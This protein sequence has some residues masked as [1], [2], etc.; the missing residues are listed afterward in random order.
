MLFPA[1]RLPGAGQW[2]NWQ[3]LVLLD[4]LVWVSVF[5]GVERETQ[6]E[7]FGVGW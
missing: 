2:H 1:L 5:D 3:L 7:Y 6:I 4:F